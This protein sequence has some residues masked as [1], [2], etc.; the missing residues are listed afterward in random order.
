MQTDKIRASRTPSV[1]RRTKGR[2]QDPPPEPRDVFT[3]GGDERPS[4]IAGH[5]LDAKKMAALTGRKAAEVLLNDDKDLLRKETVDQLSLW[6]CPKQHTSKS[7]TV[8]DPVT[9]TLYTGVEPKGSSDFNYWRLRAFSSDGSE[10]WTFRG[11]YV[12][13]PPVPDGKGNVYI[14]SKDRLYLLDKDGKEIS[15]IHTESSSWSDTPPALG[16][17][18]EVYFIERNPDGYGTGD[19]NL[20][21]TAVKKGKKIWS[22][23]ASG[24]H[25]GDPKVL[26]GKDGS[27][28]LLASRNR[29]A[30]TFGGLLGVDRKEIPAL[31]GLD[32]KDGTEKFVVPLHSLDSWTR[33]PAAVGPD[34]TIYACHERTKMAAVSPKGKKKWDYDF[35][36]QNG[37]AATGEGSRFNQPPGFDA[38]GNIYVGT[39][40]V[41][42]T[43]DGLLICLTPCG[44][45]KWRLAVPGGVETT[46]L[47]GPDGNLYCGT[48]HGDLLIVDRTTGARIS[49]FSVGNMGENNFSFGANGEIF[50]NMEDKVVALQPDRARLTEKQT[51]ERKEALESEKGTEAEAPSVKDGDDFVSIDGVKLKKSRRGRRE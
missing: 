28:F 36:E 41:S 47:V 14:R 49:R 23:P 11:K 15:A 16:P 9:D 5:S 17:D 3:A 20:L 38:E 48:G 37:A 27:V 33:G 46:P 51:A 31:I 2:A 7:D 24:D 34:G 13:S 1:P 32:P 8:Y 44:T 19:P 43:P 25:T 22:Y 12:E 30:Y 10:K 29:K 42:T 35:L 45:E 6:Q 39:T 21:L 50:I 40:R 26:T 18:G 4:K